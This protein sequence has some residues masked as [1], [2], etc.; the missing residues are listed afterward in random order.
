MLD[1][2]KNLDP[3]VKLSQNESANLQKKSAT[4]SKFS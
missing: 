4:G 1:K 3:K 2:W